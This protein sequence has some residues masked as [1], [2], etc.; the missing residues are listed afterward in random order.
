M[1]FK[2]SLWF[3]AKSLII[4]ALVA[5]VLW[6]A[7]GWAFNA[8]TIFILINDGFEKRANVILHANAPTSEDEAE[9]YEYFA[10]SALQHD[11]D[12]LDSPYA[13]ISV[14][15]FDYSVRIRSIRVYPWS[16]EALVVADE[17]V[18]NIT[19]SVPESA[20]RTDLPTEVPQWNPQRYEITMKKNS[21]NRWYIEALRSL[22]PADQPAEPRATA[23]TSPSP[24]PTP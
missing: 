16:D 4:F 22:G 13:D 6:F 21:D 17:L 11:A 14:T 15:A 9:L 8:S 19:G 23:S 3:L 5:A 10:S 2:R 12:V 18:S 1:Y 7:F 20:E 24:T